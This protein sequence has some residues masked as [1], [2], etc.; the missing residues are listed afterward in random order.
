M[1]NLAYSP[2]PLVEFIAQRLNVDPLTVLNKQLE[3]NGMD[4][5]PPTPAMEVVNKLT[6]HTTTD[7]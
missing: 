3:L 6:P 5:L 4:A 7:Y 1:V 2:G